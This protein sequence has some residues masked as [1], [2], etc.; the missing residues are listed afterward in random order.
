MTGPYPGRAQAALSTLPASLAARPRDRRGLP[1]PFVQHL[2]PDG[3]PDFTQIDAS[4]VIRCAREHRCGLC[5]EPL[6]GKVSFLGGP[7]S[8]AAQGGHGAYIDP[9]MHPECARAALDLCPHMAVQQAL[10]VR[11]DASNLTPHHDPHKPDRWVLLTAPGFSAELT[12]DALIFL[13]HPPGTK[14]HFQY[15]GGLLHETTGDAP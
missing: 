8:A 13:P 7:R 6:H 4:K 12:P 5:G 15:E 3:Q 14:R 1:I 2:G 10:R 9:P 11:G